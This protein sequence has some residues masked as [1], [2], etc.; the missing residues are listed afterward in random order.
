MEVKLKKIEKDIDLGD[1]VQYK[2][3]TCLVVEYAYCDGYLLIALEGTER[4]RTLASYEYLSDIDE[5]VDVIYII[6]GD[7][8]QI[9]ENKAEEE[10]VW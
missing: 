10:Y 6:S 8:V 4:Y 3:I 2:N 9:S 5:D 1:L 7:D